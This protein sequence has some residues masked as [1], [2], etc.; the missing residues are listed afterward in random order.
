[1]APSEQLSQRDL[2]QEAKKKL[3]HQNKDLDFSM[4]KESAAY[5]FDSSRRDS[6][7]Q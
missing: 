6:S 4:D 3:L 7:R 2:E 1:M 5:R